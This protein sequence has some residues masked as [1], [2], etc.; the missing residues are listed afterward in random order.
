MGTVYEA[1][2]ERFDHQVAIKETHFTEEALRKQF[3][4]EARLLYKLRH[5]AIAR[6]IDHFTEGE[7]QYLVMDYIEGDDLWERLQKRDGA[8]PIEDVLKWGDQLLDA[9]HYLH[10]QEPPVIHRDIKPQNLKVTG[11]DQIILLDFGLAKGFAGQ[12]SRVTTSGSIFGYTP[13]YAPLEQIQGTG[14]DARSDLY[15]LAAT[16]YHLLTGK[17]PPDVL[18]RLSSTA[19][20]QPDPL[21]LAHELNPQVPTGVSDVL[22]KGMAVGNRQRFANAADMRQALLETTQPASVSEA[23]MST[24]P[25]AARDLPPTQMAR[26][27]ITQEIQ[28]TIASPAPNFEPPRT[29]PPAA[30]PAQKVLPLILIA[31]GILTLLIIIFVQVSRN[32]E[33]DDT[34]N[35]N[36]TSTIVKNSNSSNGNGNSNNMNSNRW[37]ANTGT[38]M[39]M[40]MRNINRKP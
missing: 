30:S 17:V 27:V 10:S 12:I 31:G 21:R 19:N 2:D 36:T 29:Q 28:P 15:S 8:F 14:T 33:S 35:T 5:P 37:N 22:H 38:A 6:V 9:L 24:Q 25:P 7:G 34:S 16:L 1:I 11:R 20:G 18:T 26:E 32:S 13:N 3:E 23:K 4:R 39:N 40:N